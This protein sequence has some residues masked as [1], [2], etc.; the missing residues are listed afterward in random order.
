MSRF[1]KVFLQ[2]CLGLFLCSLLSLEAQWHGAGIV[3]TFQTDVTNGMDAKGNTTAVWAEWYAKENHIY[4]SDKIF[5]TTNYWT[6]ATII[7]HAENVTFDRLK[8][9]VD[10][11]WNAI[12]IWQ[13]RDHLQER[14]LKAS[15]R[16]Y[17]G[18]WSAPVTLSAISTNDIPSE[19]A[20]NAS[21]HAIVVWS[22]DNGIYASTFHPGGSWSTPH[23]ICGQGHNPKVKIDDQGN[24]LVVWNNNGTIQS[25]SLPYGG[26]WSSPTHISNTNGAREPQLN[27][28]RTGLAVVTW[29]ADSNM[30]AATMQFGGDWSAPVA[31]KATSH[32]GKPDLAVDGQGNAMLVWE[33]QDLSDGSF[34][35]LSPKYIQ[36][37]YFTA[38]H[39]SDPIT[40]SQGSP[41]GDFNPRVAFDGQGKAYVVWN[42]YSSVLARTCSSNVWSSVET[43]QED[44]LGILTRPQICVASSGYAIVNWSNED[45]SVLSAKWSIP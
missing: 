40:L 28:N 38:K 11:A 18:A 12:V 33:Q 21:G 44:R 3:S 34:P 9:V 10:A 1:N 29:S 20:V 19:L 30:N 22:I 27:M 15:T 26:Q 13:E 7:H 45:G 24:V 23:A 5:E 2:T 43:I 31:I 36:S 35:L 39:W 8:L 14:V 6:P 32:V 16:P 25:A 42:S 41:N 37:S 4:S 17:Q